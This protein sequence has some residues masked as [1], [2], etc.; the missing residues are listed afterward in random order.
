MEYSVPWWSDRRSLSEPATERIPSP[1]Q[2]Y[3]ANV[4]WP[5]QQCRVVVF[6]RSDSFPNNKYQRGAP[7][8]KYKALVLDNE[9]ISQRISVVD[10]A[11]MQKLQS[12]ARNA[13]MLIVLMVLRF[14]RQ[15]IS[16]LLK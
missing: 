6:A 2:L 14:Q 10:D 12:Y 9:V 16:Y 8:I 15:N 13:M 3:H 11:I 5:G 4:I 7:L 1:D